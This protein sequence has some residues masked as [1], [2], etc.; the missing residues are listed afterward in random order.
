MWSLLPAPSSLCDP[1]HPQGS[2]LPCLVG[3]S[4]SCS[5][6]KREAPWGPFLL[7][8]WKLPV[9]AS[10]AQAFFCDSEK[11]QRRLLG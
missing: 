10:F 11:G 4:A 9:E 1:R 6:T 7:W 8:M 2:E 5:D 3:T